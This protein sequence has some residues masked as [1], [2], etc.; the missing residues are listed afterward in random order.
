MGSRKKMAAETNVKF[1]IFAKFVDENEDK[2]EF[3]R[4][5]YTELMRKANESTDGYIWQ[6]DSF[7]IQGELVS[8]AGPPENF[9][10]LDGR[11]N[12]GENIE[13]EWFI[14]HILIRLSLAD[15]NSVI[16]V[17]DEDGQFLLIEACDYLP[18]WLKPDM[19]ENRVFIHNGQIHIIPLP[20]NPSEISIFPTGK[21]SLS[22]ALNLVLGSQ[23]TIASAAVQKSIFARIN[24]FNNG[25]R[26]IFHRAHCYIP[27]YLAF[28]LKKEPAIVN[29]I[30]EE[31]KDFLSSQKLRNKNQAI[32]HLDDL[33][34]M[35]YH[36]ETICF[37]KFSYAQLMYLNLDKIS[38]SKGKEKVKCSNQKAVQI[39]EKLEIGFHL[40]YSKF[41]EQ[42]TECKNAD[43]NNERWWKYL[44]NLKKYGYF[45]DE[46]QGSLAWKNLYS[47]AEEYFNNVELSFEERKARQLSQL[48]S[49]L[50]EAKLEGHTPDELKPEDDGSWLEVTDEQLQTFLSDRYGNNQ[51]SQD[52]DVDLEDVARNMKTFV[53]KESD[54]EGVETE[55]T[56][57]TF[58]PVSIVKELQ[59]IVDGKTVDHSDEGEDSDDEFDD[60]CE[61][62]DDKMHDVMVSMEEELRG[63]TIG[64]SFEKKPGD[65]D[66][67]T[68]EEAYAKRKERGSERTHG[69]EDFE[70]NDADIEDVPLDI[71][72][73]LVKNFLESVSSQEGLTGPVSNLLTSIGISLPPN[74]DHLE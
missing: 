65:V 54:F 67:T 42:K 34:A 2:D 9:A 23:K 58:D 35:D 56:E 28:I 39:G 26:H 18:E 68:K 38:I 32:P 6:R 50:E 55:N 36:L 29:K 25:L 74:S 31:I 13:D 71:D 66:V 72:F 48:T 17:E 3:K 37:T 19:A 21:P 7:T 15:E 64:R 24:K 59:R 57:I 22:Q 40:L 44:E 1:A 10:R 46:I 33:E 12:C 73:N 11:I 51:G 16:C 8:T 63:T 69:T 52:F 14:V 61:A 30:L 60:E 53:N 70:Q 20:S 5:K 45:K 41:T 47:K 49:L 62:V 43:H 27:S 4:R